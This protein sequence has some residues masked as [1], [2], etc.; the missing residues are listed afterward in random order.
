MERLGLDPDVCL[1]RNPKLVFGRITGWDQAGL[2]ANAVSHDI[3][4]IAL[5]GMVSTFACERERPLPPGKVAGDMSGGGLLLAYGI[6]YALLE[7]RSSGCGQ[8]VDAA[9]FEGAATLGVS[10]FT[11]EGWHLHDSNRPGTN[12]SDGGSRFL[13]MICM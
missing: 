9:M 11:M 5:S 2:L 4:Y 10:L 7:A 12:V 1:A 6:S 8:V 13:I 3:D